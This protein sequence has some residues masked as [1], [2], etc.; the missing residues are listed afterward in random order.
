MLSG[1]VVGLVQTVEGLQRK[2]WS[3]GGT[4]D[5]SPDAF[6]RDL[7]H[8]LSGVCS[9]GASALP[10]SDPPAPQSCEPTPAKK[11]LSLHTHSHTHRDT[12][13]HRHTH[14]H[15]DTHTHRDTHRHTRTHAHRNLT[16]KSPH[17]HLPTAL[18]QLEDL[19]SGYPP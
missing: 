3:P 10:V 19:G 13:R 18:A 4:W 16:N 7:P 2:A 15:T 5:S 6:G 17:R 11:P 1:S 14:S 9:P 12:H 8:L